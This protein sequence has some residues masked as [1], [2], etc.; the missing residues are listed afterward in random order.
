MKSL[1]LLPFLTLFALFLFF[2]F[3]IGA[4]VNRLHPVQPKLVQ[5]IKAT[6]PIIPTSFSPGETNSAQ[7]YPL[8]GDN[9]L[10]T[11]QRNIL[12]IGIDRLEAAEPR[13]EGIW[14]ALYVPAS[15]KIT[16]MPIYPS[17]T[18]NQSGHKANQDAALASSF[19][20]DDKHKPDISFLKTLQDRGLWWNNFVVLDELAMVQIID[21]T[22]PMSDKGEMD[23]EGAY[24]LNGIRTLADLPLPWENPLAAVLSQ[25][26]LLADLC[27]EAPEVQSGPQVETSIFS[28]QLSHH[29]VTDINPDQIRRD[30][31]NMMG[32]GTGI[33]CEFPSL[34]ASLS[35][36]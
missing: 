14:L 34:K 31:S 10:A 22:D 32:I 26:K 23:Q 5:W 4:A 21:L 28:D 16:L 11:G 8:P 18:Q 3:R 25:A 27:H 33:S 29:L 20:L 9:H 7:S 13:L 15:P 30:W 35:Q 12:I 1:R 36:R 6:E 19:R 24:Q 2:G 17:L